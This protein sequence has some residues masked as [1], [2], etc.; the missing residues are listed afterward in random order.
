MIAPSKAGCVLEK[1][2]KLHMPISLFVLTGTSKFI[3]IFLAGPPIM[4]LRLSKRTRPHNFPPPF[5]T[6]E[7][8]FFP[9]LFQLEAGDIILEINRRDVHSCT[10]KEGKLRT[11]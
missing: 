4:A 6:I 10:T 2:M 7:L 1:A 11:E 9:L 5:S 3:C 8:I